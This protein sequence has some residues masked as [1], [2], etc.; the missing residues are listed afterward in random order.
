MRQRLGLAEILV[1]QAEIAIL[2]E[3]T[4]GLDPQA[5]IEFLQMIGELKGSR[6]LRGYRGAPLANE[7]ALRDTLLRISELVTVAPELHE[8]DLNPVIVTASTACAADVRIRIGDR[9]VRRAGRR[10]E[11]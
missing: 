6:L 2:D 9:T 5:T 4:S 8:L 3:P 10:V 7:A 1:K 11:Y